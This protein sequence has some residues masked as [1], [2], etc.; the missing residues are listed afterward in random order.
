MYVF[1]GRNVNELYAHAVGNFFSKDVTREVSPRGVRT[2]EFREPVTSVYQRPR[3]RVL[4]DITRDANPFFHLME[5]LWIL[6]G[7]RDVKWLSHFNKNIVNYS[8]DG[9]VFHGAYGYRLHG[10]LGDVFEC[11]KADPDSRRG[12]ASIWDPREDSALTQTSDLPCNTTLYFK[13]REGLLNLTVCCR[14]NDAWWGCYGANAVQ[15][16]IIQE[17]VADKLGVGVGA[18]RQIS[19]SLHSYVDSGPWHR[20]K[21]GYP[22]FG[23]DWY[24]L[25]R[26]TE[27][28]IRADITSFDP[29]LA[30]VMSI[31]QYRYMS[32]VPDD[33]PG[34][35]FFD[36][37]VIPMMRAWGFHKA[38]DNR[39]GMEA[40]E[41]FM[42]PNSDWGFAAKQWLR[43]R[44][45]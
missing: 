13:L 20:I 45:K 5:A 25:D 34:H 31:P 10:Q 22:G 27:T 8:D 7:R 3:E 4:F 38:G 26:V 24:A 35:P 39:A 40:I 6:V 28:P 12:V 11:L 32:L 23:P 18:Y 29:I 21:D 2:I 30:Y 9:K 17:Y 36:G 14:S 42:A 37:T 16:S 44:I 33:H 19:D 15:F 43:R 41:S 1:R